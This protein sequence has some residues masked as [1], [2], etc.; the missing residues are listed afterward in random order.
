MITYRTRAAYAERYGRQHQPDHPDTIPL[1][2]DETVP[3]RK[4]WPT[5]RVATYLH[6][7][8]QKF[9][10]RFDAQSYVSLTHM[11]DTHDIMRGR[12]D[13]LADAMTPLKD[14]PVLILGIDSDV[15]YPLE[16]QAELHALL[17]KKSSFHVIP[18]LYGHDGF[19]LEQD[20]ISAAVT[21][22]LRST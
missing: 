16:E 8:G 9:H 2:S 14:L 7:Q 19:L 12:G 18:S 15:L 10:R 20:A 17:P 3:R 6:Y 11:M 22:F 21:Q 1:S 13:T 4:P 5:F